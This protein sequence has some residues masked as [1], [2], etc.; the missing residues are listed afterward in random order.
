MRLPRIRFTVW[1]VMAAVAV[2]AVG[3]G[4]H[5]QL[6]R[7]RQLAR[8]YEIRARRLDRWVAIWKH[9]AA[10]SHY[11]WVEDCR[12]VDAVNQKGGP[13]ARRFKAIIAPGIECPSGAGPHP[14]LKVTSSSPSW[15]S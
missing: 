8:S 5:A 10:R 15:P 7:W 9:Y 6:A 4:V 3:L 13:K 14:G 12:A 2:V 11:Q 1:R